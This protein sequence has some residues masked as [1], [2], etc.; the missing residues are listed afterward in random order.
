ML[1]S[2][3][4]KS[5]FDNESPKPNS[6]VYVLNADENTAIWATYDNVLDVWTKNFLGESPDDAKQL[7]SNIFKSK[8]N[9]GFSY[10]KKAPIK[11]L[12]YPEAEIYKDT[13][14]GDL[15]HVSMYITQQ[16]DINRVDVFADTKYV[17]KDFKVNSVK[18]YKA[19]E[20]NNAFENRRGNRLFSYYVSDK[21][22]LSLEFSIPKDQETKFKI[23]ES[24]FDLLS[25]P[26]FTIPERSESMMPKPFI[27]NDAVIITKTIQIN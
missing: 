9:S 18:A 7:S 16:R 17:F 26:L 2:A 22:S 24:S 1:I 21:D 5:G 27:L 20:D 23:Y 4:F 8:Y 12:M 6:L 10:S 3:H 19:H 25:N 11:A 15:R 14:I 13:V